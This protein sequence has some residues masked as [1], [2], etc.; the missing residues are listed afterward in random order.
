MDNFWVIKASPKENILP[1]LLVKNKEDTWH[2]K[3]EIPG[4]LSYGDTMFVWATSP[5]L[6]LIGV[7]AFV[8]T[9]SAPNLGRGDT[10]EFLLQYLSQYTETNLDITR[11]KKDHVLNGEEVP[12]FLKA[13]PTQTIYPLSRKQGKRLLQL[14]TEKIDVSNLTGNHRST[15]HSL[16][17]NRRPSIVNRIVRDTR[18]TKEIKSLYKHNCQICGISLEINSGKYAEGAHIKPLGKP[19]NGDDSISNILCLCP[20]HHVLLDGG[21]L[22][23][24]D[25]FEVVPLG[26]KLRMDRNHE[27]DLENLQYH[28]RVIFGD[29]S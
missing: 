26:T 29:T 5:Q 6:E 15:L 10:R 28:R 16:E 7:A 9:L 25:E 13:G 27:L 11:L 24:S 20:N 2:T 21:A 1:T 8:R 4:N 12:S 18:L 23:I 14:V 22:Y 17:P 19:H 3:R